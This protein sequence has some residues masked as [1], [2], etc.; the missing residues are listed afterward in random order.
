MRNVPQRWQSWRFRPVRL[1]KPAELPPAVRFRAT[2]IDPETRSPASP[3][4]VDYRN[5]IPD[6][7]GI[8]RGF[9]A[10][11]Q[12]LIAAGHYDAPDRWALA[13]ELLFRRMEEA[14]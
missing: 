1:S 12:R 8:R 13:E 2:M 6:A 9:V 4:P 10:H 3:E 7:H 11:I 14:R 5:E